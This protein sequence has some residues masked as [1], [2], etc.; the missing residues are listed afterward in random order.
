MNLH[1]SHYKSGF[2]KHF[3]KNQQLYSPTENHYILY[4]DKA[5]IEGVE[6]Q[7][8][9]VVE[10]NWEAL[11]AFVKDWSRYKA[12]YLHYL[13]P[14]LAEVLQQL[15]KAIKKVWVFWGGDGFTQIKHYLDDY[16]LREQTKAYYDQHLRPK[17]K[18]CKNPFYLYKNYQDYK[19][20][21]PTK[22]YQN[23][24]EAVKQV[25]YFAHYIPADFELLQQHSS[26]NAQFIAFNY[27][28]N[29]Q[30]HLPQHDLTNSQTDMLIGNSADWSNNHLDLFTQLSHYQLET[31]GKIYVP[32]S[33][34]GN[35]EYKQTVL[36][37]GKKQ[38]GKQWIPLLDYLPLEEYN[39]ILSTIS[40]AVIGTVRSQAAGN[41]LALLMQGTR[42]YLDK[43][44]TLFQLLKAEGMVLF[45]LDNDLEQHLKEGQTSF[46]EASI[47]QQN[48]QIIE[49][50]FGKEAI[51]E[52]YIHLLELTTTVPLT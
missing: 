45:D 24:L 18:W 26:L 22:F 46:L 48:Q 35:E 2:I 20:S 15:P 21:Y 25:D 44:S 32:L 34:G 23:Y 43:R 11:D 17:M 7:W 4:G 10:A 29:E 39:T 31:I 38:L 52:K 36:E 41:V 28:S 3:M 51:K 42:V 50:I 5:T 19:N 49:R 27:M 14:F 1:L 40:M 16:C 8:F 6:K 47:T 12:V 33:Y 37:V 13:S 9:E 30:F